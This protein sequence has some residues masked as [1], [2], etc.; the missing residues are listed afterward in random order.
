MTSNSHLLAGD[1]GHL[2]PALEPGKVSCIVRMHDPSRLVEL[3][4]C[5]FSLCGQQHAS[6][7]AVIVTQRF[8]P[9]QLAAIHSVT[10]RLS[11]LDPAP[12]FLV[13]N[14]EHA[15]P[16]DARSALLNLGIRFADGQ[17]LGFLDYDDTL[18]PEAY[19][20]LVRR[21]QST[22]AAIAFASV[23]VVN[24]DVHSDAG[25]V[26]PTGL[27]ATNFVG[28]GSYD[29][30]FRGNFCPIHSYLIDRSRIPE[31]MSWFDTSMTFEEDYDLLLRICWTLPSDFELLRTP[32]GE[33]Y[34]KSDASNSSSVGVE[35]RGPVPPVERWMRAK[36]EARRVI[37]ALAEKRA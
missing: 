2:P 4:R 3:E 26:R 32:I 20:L 25:F 12:Q 35:N 31:T 8:N 24:A 23:Q 5:L 6:V 19:S 21:L 28:T 11:E 27:R 18:Y 36:I 17:Y 10:S 33:Y 1:R 9:T 7:Q 22:R 16:R 29:L 37:C 14:Y 15:E 34:Y 30:L 13:L